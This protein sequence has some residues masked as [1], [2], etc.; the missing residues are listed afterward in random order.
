MSPLAPEAAHVAA[1]MNAAYLVRL[2]G[3]PHQAHQRAQALRALGEAARAA[4]S[5]TADPGPALYAIADGLYPF[6]QMRHD[7]RRG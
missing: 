1:I 3:R 4:L 7:R 5:G 6:E 2:Y